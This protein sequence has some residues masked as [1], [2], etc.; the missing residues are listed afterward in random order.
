MTPQISNGV[1][2]NV[3]FVACA[4]GDPPFSK[5]IRTANRGTARH[6]ATTIMMFAIGQASPQSHRSWDDALRRPGNNDQDAGHGNL[7]PF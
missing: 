2:C 5:L 3:T 1:A 4:I 6:V 7:F